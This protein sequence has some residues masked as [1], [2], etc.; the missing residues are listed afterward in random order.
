MPHLPGGRV[1]RCA[2]AQVAE[3]LLHAPDHAFCVRDVLLFDRGEVVQEHFLSG[4]PLPGRACVLRQEVE[5][6]PGE[7]IGSVRRPSAQR[8]RF[9]LRFKSGIESGQVQLGITNHRQFVAG[10]CVVFMTIGAGLFIGDHVHGA[11]AV[12]GGVAGGAGEAF[13]MRCI[14]FEAVRHPFGGVLGL[15]REVLGVVAKMIKENAGAAAGRI[16]HRL[17]IGV[18]VGKA[19]ELLLMT[20]LALAVGERFQVRHEAVMLVVAGAAG[21]LLPAAAGRDRSLFSSQIRS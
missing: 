20:H 13:A 14:G 15:F 1:R 4:E 8:A 11:A 19:L 6:E 18:P 12:V 9:L 21:E 7:I 17:K 2:G 16:G 3:Q 5:D 10:A